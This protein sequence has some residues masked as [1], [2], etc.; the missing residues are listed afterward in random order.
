MAKQPVVCFQ[1][2]LLVLATLGLFISEKV[3]NFCLGSGSW[4]GFSLSSIRSSWKFLYAVF[5]RALAVRRSFAMSEGATVPVERLI[6]SVGSPLNGLIHSVSIKS[7]KDCT[8]SSTFPIRG[9]SKSCWLT[10]G[11][12]ISFSSLSCVR[13]VLLYSAV[14]A[15]KGKSYHGHL[16]RV[17][18]H[19]K[20][21]QAGL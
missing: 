12:L 8:A 18:S 7:T 9:D 14:N 19:G 16:P 4:K 1:D 5:P 17:T 2:S 13:Q 11:C 3:F 20:E 10:P 15:N 21:L 6:S